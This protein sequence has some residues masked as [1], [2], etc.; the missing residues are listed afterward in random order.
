MTPN[1]YYFFKF[2]Y[3]LIDKKTYRTL[4]GEI[5][6][7]QYNANVA[8]YENEGITQT[9]YNT[10]RTKKGVIIKN[11]KAKTKRLNKKQHLRATFKET[12]QNNNW[13]DIAL[14]IFIAILPDFT[15]LARMK[16][17]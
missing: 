3:F 13:L 9:K 15:F 8:V 10:K 17:I 4:I 7:I 6:S 11:C 16:T 1:Y 5:T 2:I 14:F 12:Y